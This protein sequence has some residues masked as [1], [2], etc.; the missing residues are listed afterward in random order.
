MA[1]VGDGPGDGRGGEWRY[2]VGLG[3]NVR[4][5]RHGPPRRVLRAALAALAE[6]GVTIEA[7]SPM[8]T[9]P[10][11]GH[12]RRRYA[13]AAA[14]LATRIE[15]EALLALLQ[16]IEYRFGRRRRGRRWGERVLDLD[17]LLWSGG[18]WSGPG[19][20]VPHVAF[21][22]RRFALTPARA[23][24]P[25]W[26]DPITG[27]TLRHLHARLTQPRPLPIAHPHEGP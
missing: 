24:A 10:P 14:L 20:L 22:Q 13:N 6:A 5:H 11:L 1:K 8:L 7:V 23:V 21:R 27:L 26:R 9:T 3:S 19:L 2:V 4:H 18:A 15:P 16:D 17:I 12:A 25:R